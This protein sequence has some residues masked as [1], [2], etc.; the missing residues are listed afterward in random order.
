MSGRLY[1]EDV[2]NPAVLEPA[3]GASP[4]QPTHTIHGGLEP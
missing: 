1:Y 3:Q 2:K 4:Q